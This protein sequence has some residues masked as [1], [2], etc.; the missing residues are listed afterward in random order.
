MRNN[1]S[2][3][4]VSRRNLS[5]SLKTRIFDINRRIRRRNENATNGLV[6]NKIK[7]NRI[8]LR[9][10]AEIVAVKSKSEES[11]ILGINL[12]FELTCFEERSFVY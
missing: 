3:S 6:L 7:S 10:R 12:N 1:N 2:E 8:I 11:R 5:I 9:F 4:M